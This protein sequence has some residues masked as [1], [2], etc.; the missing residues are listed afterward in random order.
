MI[1]AQNGSRVDAFAAGQFPRSLPFMFV[2]A[3]FDSPTGYEAFA[4]NDRAQPRMRATYGSYSV[5]P[6]NHD[7]REGLLRPLGLADKQGLK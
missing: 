6:T 1:R 4:P 3:D 7:E 5:H 2:F